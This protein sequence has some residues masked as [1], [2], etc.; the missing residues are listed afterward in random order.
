MTY[1]EPMETEPLMSDKKSEYTFT[2]REAK[3][4]EYDIDMMG[5]QETDRERQG[6]GAKPD[7][8][9][10][11]KEVCTAPGKTSAASGLPGSLANYVP[12][13]SSK[14]HQQYEQE[15][16]VEYD[17]YQGLYAKM[18]TLSRVFINLDSKRKHLSPDS[19]KY[20]DI[21]KKISLEYQ[22]M[23][24]INPNYY[25]EKH[26]CQYLYNKLAHIKR[27]INDYDQQH[28]KS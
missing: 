23:K 3:D 21:N 24:Q 17:E 22:K 11:V 15:F 10:E 9:Q 8:K 14:Q 16:R 1:P 18:L 2:E 7:S 4:Q 20:Q 5:R 12:I 27:L 6:E 25:A 19:K 28:I 13:V 26:R